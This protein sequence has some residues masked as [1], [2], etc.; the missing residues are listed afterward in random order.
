MKVEI[1]KDKKSLIITLPL[2]NP[3]RPSKSGKTLVVATSNGNK[4]SGCKINVD[5]EEKDITVGVNA[6][7]Y[8]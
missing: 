2:V 5:G 4:S 1:S 3:I 7:V 8:P 6:Y